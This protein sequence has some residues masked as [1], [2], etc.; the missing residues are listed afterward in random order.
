MIIIFC[1][2]FNLDIVFDG[3]DEVEHEDV[4]VARED[5]EGL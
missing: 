1:T 5:A 3:R 4:P 2:F